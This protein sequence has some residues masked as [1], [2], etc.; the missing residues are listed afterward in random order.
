MSSTKLA[1]ALFLTMLT[2][3]AVSALHAQDNQPALS[4]GKVAVPPA[5]ESALKPAVGI[6]EPPLKVVCKGNQLTVAANDSTLAS[7][8]NEVQ[9]CTGAK[10]DIPADAAE[11]RFFDTIGPLPIQEG[12][13]VLLTASGYNFVIQSS[14]SE[15]E[16]LESVLLMPRATSPAADIANERPLTPAR[17]VFLKMRQNALTE[18]G[19]PDQNSPSTAAESTATPL[20]EPPSA[21]SESDAT[22]RNAPA[23]GNQGAAAPPPGTTP[24]ENPAPSS[25][26]S[27]AA[28]PASEPKTVE[29]QI[30][31]M[32]QMFEQRR[33]MMQTPPSSPH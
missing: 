18:A 24:Q 10:I 15:P 20:T 23:D 9:R 28:P 22:N 5:S 26:A 1:Q 6:P 16:K 32:Q 14:Q 19:I 3:C 25:P 27:E 11:I 12:L 8:L 7:I 33:Q 21:N 2:A 17:R 30:T 29:D 31:N 13:S 4:D